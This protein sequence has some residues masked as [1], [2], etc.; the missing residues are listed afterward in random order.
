MDSTTGTGPYRLID[1]DTHVNEPPELWVER[2]PAKYR[3]QVP[4]MVRFEE[5]DA[6]VL[7]RVKDPINFGFNVAATF[8]KDKRK[9]WVRFEDIPRGGYDPAV[10]LQE[11]DTDLV[12]AA[13]FYPTPRLSHL[14][15]ATPEPD[16]H[17]AMVRAYNDWLIEYCSHDPS[18]LGAIPL[19]PN[20]G[21]DQA[22]AEIER[23]AGHP[24]VKGLLVGLYP[25][26][27]KDLAPEDDAVWKL[28]TETGLAVHIHVGL[29]DEFPQDI[30][31]A[32]R[33]TAGHAAGDL[34][35]L[36][37]PM[38]MA[39]FLSSGVFDRIRDLIVVFVE[40]DAGWVPYVKEQL[41]NRFRRRAVGP[42]A[43]RTMLPSEYIDRHFRYTYITDHYAVQ[44]RHRVGVENLMWSSDFPH[45]GS[46]WPDSWRTIDADF[47]GV[48]AAERD[49]IL[50]GN[51]Q[52][53][54]RF[55]S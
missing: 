16:L 49:L 9:A 21:I 34:R 7:D 40:V 30:Y 20:R 50:S 19:V 33:I 8:P 13:V 55:G 10:R 54:Y 35:F 48:P 53:L 43:R 31:R 3:D 11:M 29:V 28:A 23:V 46:D 27:D 39:Q 44:N 32:D 18:R 17:L 15:I 37:A 14:V 5:G 36:Q 2:V 38:L 1:A 45:T 26:G 41:D 4:R 22:L 24:A 6:W 42:A 25:H 51:A 47:A 12:D 52:R